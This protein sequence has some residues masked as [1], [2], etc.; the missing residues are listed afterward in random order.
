M[1]FLFI[2]YLFSNSFHD[3]KDESVNAGLLTHHW[4]HASQLSGPRVRQRD[5]GQIQSF[6]KC[7]CCLLAFLF[8]LVLFSVLIM[9]MIEKETV[10]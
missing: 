2:S 6:H 5:A 9:R 3:F 1:S 10:F 4:C 7:V 8:V